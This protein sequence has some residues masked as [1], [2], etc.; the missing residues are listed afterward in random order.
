VDVVDT[1]DYKTQ[2]TVYYANRFGLAIHRASGM[3]A[4]LF[5]STV[6]EFRPFFRRNNAPL[7]WSNNAI[8]ESPLV[9]VDLLL[10]CT[11]TAPVYAGPNCGGGGHDD[12]GH[13]GFVQVRAPL[14]LCKVQRTRVRNAAAALFCAN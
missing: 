2:Y 13:Q 1:N 7:A 11:T 5:K 3:A 8:R 10:T 9:N 14:H 4:R 12:V 6:R